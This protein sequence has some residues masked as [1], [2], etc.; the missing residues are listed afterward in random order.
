MKITYRKKEI[1]LRLKRIEGQ[2]RGLQK[3]VDDETSCADILTQ[4]AAVT[5]AIKRVGRAVVQTYMEECFKRSQEQPGKSKAEAM[6]N[7]QK[8]IAQ[9]IDWA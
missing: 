8:A 3:M 4:V 5:G 9:Y 2:V 1:T 7:L 6:K